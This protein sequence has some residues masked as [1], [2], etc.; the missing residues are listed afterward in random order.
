ME[1]QVV[2]IVRELG[3]LG[4][5]VFAAIYLFRVYL[6]KIHRQHQE[7]LERIVNATERIMSAQE[8][9][10]RSVG[11]S[12]AARQRKSS[13]NIGKLIERTEGF[14]GDL[15]EHHLREETILKEHTRQ[16]ERIGEGVEKLLAK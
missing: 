12:L 3:S 6:P 14:Q 13:E 7:A 2:L 10:F 16:L 4:I 15:K 1:E 9:T 11:Q 5:L 8:S